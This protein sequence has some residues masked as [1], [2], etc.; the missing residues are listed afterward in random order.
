M[1]DAGAIQAG[2]SGHGPSASRRQANVE[3]IAIGNELSELSRRPESAP[4]VHARQIHPDL[5]PIQGTVGHALMGSRTVLSR[6]ARR[7]KPLTTRLY[8]GPSAVF[9][10]QPR[11]RPHRVE[12]I[13]RTS[14]RG[15]LIAIIVPQWPAMGMC[16]ATMG[17]SGRGQWPDRAPTATYVRPAGSVGRDDGLVLSGVEFAPVVDPEARG[18]ARAGRAA[19]DVLVGLGGH[20][21]RPV[22][23]GPSRVTVGAG[24]WLKPAVGACGC[25]GVAST[26]GRGVV[27]LCTARVY[28]IGRG[29]KTPTVSP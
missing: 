21:R 27:W 6:H 18:V 26:V 5:P 19:Q 1:Q 16:A 28:S 4:C 12:G 23:A 14:V 25:R 24:E 8:P 17:G 13:L 22:P 2:C 20:G 15:A 9:P 10:V 3:Y 11:L 29:D 7:V